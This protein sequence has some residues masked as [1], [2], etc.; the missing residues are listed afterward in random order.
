MGGRLSGLCQSHSSDPVL[1]MNIIG[2]PIAKCSREGGGWGEY[3]P[4]TALWNGLK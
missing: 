1:V 3:Q 4:L 2:L